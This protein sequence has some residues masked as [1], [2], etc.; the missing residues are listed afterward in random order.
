MINVFIL[1]CHDAIKQFVGETVDL[2][3]PVI[4]MPTIMR[5]VMAVL[6]NEEPEATDLHSAACHYIYD[7]TGHI[8]HFDPYVYEGMEDRLYSAMLKLAGRVRNKLRHHHAYADGHFPFTFTKFV[9]D[10]TFILTR[11]READ[12]SFAHHPRHTGD[13]ERT[14]ADHD[15]VSRRNRERAYAYR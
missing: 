2:D 3:F 13:A 9:N 5:D 11:K 6:E 7:H 1:D 8:D 12:G 15:A 14:D 10:G 4:E